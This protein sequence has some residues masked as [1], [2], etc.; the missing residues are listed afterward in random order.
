MLNMKG[1]HL[2]NKDSP[3]LKFLGIVLI[4]IVISLIFLIWNKKLSNSNKISSSSNETIEEEVP[5]YIKDRLE[6][7]PFTITNNLKE[8]LKNNSITIGNEK[9]IN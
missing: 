1:K 9:E 4:I 3:K 8:L 5:Q 6:S 7:K 2:S